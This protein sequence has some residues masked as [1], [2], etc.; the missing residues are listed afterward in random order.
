MFDKIKETMKHTA[1]KTQEDM[2][3]EMIKKILKGQN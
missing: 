2:K 3:A 1:N